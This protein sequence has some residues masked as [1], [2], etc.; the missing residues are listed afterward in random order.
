[1]SYT[2]KAV[3]FTLVKQVPH[4]LKN[5]YVRKFKEYMPKKYLTVKY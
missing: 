2:Y 3:N 4:Y 1:M 5:N